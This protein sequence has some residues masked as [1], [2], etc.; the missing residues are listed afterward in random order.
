[1]VT[2]FFVLM[3]SLVL[4]LCLL[5]TLLFWGLSSDFKDLGKD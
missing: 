1:M 2:I 3:G 4:S 5:V